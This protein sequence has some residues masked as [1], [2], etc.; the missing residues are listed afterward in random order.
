[1]YLSSDVHICD[2]DHQ[3]SMSETRPVFRLV[4]PH[5]NGI[6]C[7]WSRVHRFLRWLPEHWNAAPILLPFIER[8]RHL[9][10]S[11]EPTFIKKNVFKFTSIWL[12]FEPCY[13]Q[14]TVVRAR[15]WAAAFSDSSYLAHVNGAYLRH[16]KFCIVRRPPLFIVSCGATHFNSA[17][18]VQSPRRRTPASPILV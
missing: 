14:A 9:A 16:V 2:I 11:N 8:W 5:W 10:N 4:W 18:L 15:F 17:R 12:V 3:N 13:A 6:H 1:M 7:R